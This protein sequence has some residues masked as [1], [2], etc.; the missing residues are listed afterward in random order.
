MVTGGGSNGKGKT[1]ELLKY[2]IG[3][4]NCSE[5]SPQALEED[6]FAMGE[7]VNKMVN[8]SADINNKALQ[9]TGVFKSLTGRDLDDGCKKI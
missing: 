7:L 1:L 5:I 6:M 8:I 3:I 2:L 9:N 4:E